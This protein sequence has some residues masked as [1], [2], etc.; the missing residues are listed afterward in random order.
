[1]RCRWN[2]RRMRT[3]KPNRRHYKLCMPWAS[4]TKHINVKKAAGGRPL[5]TNV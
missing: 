5:R 1:M 4:H 2:R 3:Q